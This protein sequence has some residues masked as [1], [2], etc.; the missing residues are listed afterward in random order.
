M[1]QELPGM[2]QELDD[3]IQRSRHPR[4]LT[5]DFLTVCSARIRRAYAYW[6]AKRAG[7]AMPARSDINPT[8]IPDLLPYIVLTDVLNEPPYLRYRLVGTR[9]VQMR[10]IDPTG[11]PVAGNHIGRHLAVDTT[12][13]VL[14]NY[15]IVI[16][17]R[18]FVYDNNRFL[19]PALDGGSL[20]IG[21]LHER[22]TLLLP[23]SSDGTHVDMV[24]CI[25]D[26]DPA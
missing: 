11:K 24:F 1:T 6:D 5:L 8:E 20:D 13:E 10:G 7:R 19:G 25:I 22:G 12:N 9:Q 21:Q 23:L 14:L 3:M 26:V 17:K 15:W 16:G 18:S 2:G 4:L